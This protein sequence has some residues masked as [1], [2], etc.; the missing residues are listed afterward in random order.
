[1]GSLGAGTGP[2]VDPVI[3]TGG[4]VISVT[5]LMSQTEVVKKIIPQTLD[6]RKIM[7][8]KQNENKYGK[9]HR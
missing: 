2:V 5:K 9:M 4:F 1:M 3:E 6:F 8:D 7:S